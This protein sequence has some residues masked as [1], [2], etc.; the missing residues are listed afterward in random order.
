MDR[1]SIQ[2]GRR[3]GAGLVVVACLG[4]IALW[5][6]LES[7]APPPA[8]DME[9]ATPPKSRML[10]RKPIPAGPAAAAQTSLP[11]VLRVEPAQQASFSVLSTPPEG[12]PASLRRILRRPTYGMNWALAQKLPVAVRGG[13]WA[14]PGRGWLCMLSQTSHG[15]ETTCT[16]T[17][18]AASQG[19]TAVRISGASNEGAFGAT[20]GR[21][22][23][24]GMAPDGARKMLIETPGAAA[25]TT[26]VVDGVFIHRDS[27]PNPPDSTTPL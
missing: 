16:A 15:V 20:T 3:F 4:G 23:I 19:V 22:L 25:T 10:S 17:Q 26:P 27:I 13:V 21:R 2:T 1:L 8:R 7:E 14:V 24:V 5:Q 18:Q 11:K 9:A 6:T 12:L